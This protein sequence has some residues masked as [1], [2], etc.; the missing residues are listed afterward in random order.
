[1]IPNYKEE[2]QMAKR[3][4]EQLSL[5]DDLGV[6]VKE[7][8]A[9]E[10]LTELLPIYHMQ[11]SEMDSIKKVVDKENA[12]IKTLM[13]A[14][15]LS[16]FVAGDIKA[17]CSVSER[18]DFIEEAL[19]EKLKEMKVRGIIKKKEYVDMDAL[20]NAIYNGKVDAAALASCQTTKEV[21][22]LRVSKV[23]K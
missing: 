22:T 4:L 2:K 8:R 21:V 20:E 18:Q 10:R 11:K 9:E 16:E 14:S 1:L 23:K 12:E 19:I 15:N 6:P 7:K 5:F 3:K 13:R 17:T